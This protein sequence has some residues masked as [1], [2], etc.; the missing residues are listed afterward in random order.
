[1]YII[2][3]VL[4]F[5]F[6]VRFFRFLLFVLLLFRRFLCTPC[7]SYGQMGLT[8]CH[9]LP[10][11]TVP[12]SVSEVAVPMTVVDISANDWKNT[13]DPNNIV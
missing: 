12:G 7:I 2:A 5:L 10:W 13:Q 8:G 3:V 6:F 1:M 4:L 11:K 9:S